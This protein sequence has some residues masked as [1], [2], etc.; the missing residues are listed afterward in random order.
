MN[1]QARC[2]LIGILAL[3]AMPLAT[4]AEEYMKRGASS[5]DYEA[6]LDRVLERRRGII[7]GR[8]QRAQ[9]T[10]RA[11]TAPA[12][13]PR[14]TTPAT[15]PARTASAAPVRPSARIDPEVHQA[16]ASDSA[17]ASDGISIY[18]GF[19]SAQLTP[20]ARAALGNLGQALSQ[21]RFQDIVWL[22]EGHTDSIGSAAYNQR[23]S[24]ERARAAQHFLVEQ[25]GIAA[26]KLI[27]VGKGASEPYTPE[28]P[29][30]GVN[31]RVRL[32]PI[33]GS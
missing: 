22:V 32:R 3:S 24:E 25:H 1:P 12:P 19:N 2:R 14:A 18:F 31:R 20:D 29:E 33:A 27:P 16:S 6:A 13:A 30:A 26:D 4:Q 11:S 9:S 21:P 5:A 17:T 23:L 8:E 28:R 15:P 7:T 10:Q